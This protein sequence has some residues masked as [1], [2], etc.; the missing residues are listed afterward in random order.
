MSNFK[1]GEIA[2]GQN[3]TFDIRRNNAECEIIGPLEKRNGIDSV[4]G[5]R[6]RVIGYRVRWACGESAIATPEKL[7]RKPPA[8][9]SMERMY[10]SM[11]RDL[12]GKAVQREGEVA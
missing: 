9:D 7:R 10:M 5:R 12:A 11:W 6:V 1:V 4:T 3:Y 2:I 8:A